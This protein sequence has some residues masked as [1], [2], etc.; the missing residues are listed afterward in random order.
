MV[1]EE[2][3]PTYNLASV[4]LLQKVK[5]HEGRAQLTQELNCMKVFHFLL[6][7]QVTSVTIAPKLDG[8]TI[9]S[10]KD[11]DTAP[12]AATIKNLEAAANVVGKDGTWDDKAFWGGVLN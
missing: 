3:P 10:I 6:I 9:R 1:C 2:L 12:L 4:K 5:T 11:V 8:D 7:I